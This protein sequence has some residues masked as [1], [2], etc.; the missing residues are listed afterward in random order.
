[1]VAASS[2]RGWHI[3]SNKTRMRDGLLSNGVAFL[4]L[5]RD[6]PHSND[7]GCVFVAGAWDAALKDYSSK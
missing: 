1:M 3:V 4:A 5:G 2:G 7:A 6:S